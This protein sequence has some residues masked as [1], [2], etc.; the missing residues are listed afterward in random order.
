MLVRLLHVT[1]CCGLFISILYISHC[2]NKTTIYL[3]FLLLIYFCLVSRFWVCVSAI[4]NVFPHV[5]E[6]KTYAFL[7]GIS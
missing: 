5:L 2:M 7:S 6:W 1:V 4:M 3:S